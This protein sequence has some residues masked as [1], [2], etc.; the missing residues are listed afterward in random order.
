MVGKEAG[1]LPVP[2]N[3]EMNPSTETSTLAP[4]AT[5][6]IV[7]AEEKRRGDASSQRSGDLKHADET[8]I[9]EENRLEKSNTVETIHEYP[10]AWKLGVITIALCLSVFCMALGKFD[11]SNPAAAACPSWP[12]ILNNIEC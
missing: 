2:E 1:R 8:P 11:I 10:V 5:A 3:D 4:S 12:S 7:D 6:S 9:E